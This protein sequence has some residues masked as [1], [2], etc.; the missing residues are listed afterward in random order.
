MAETFDSALVPELLVLDVERS[1]VFWRDVC[2][3]HIRY[4]RLED[5]FAYISLGSAHLMLEQIGI[6]RN[7][8]TG[9]LEAPLGRGINFQITVPSITP[10]VSALADAGID[11]LMEPETKWYRMGNEEAGVEQFLVTD[12]DGYLVRFQSSQGRRPLAR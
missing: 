6:G 8:I 7:W 10:L 4:L 2:G 11:L 12:P 9:P 3:F 5:R 1:L